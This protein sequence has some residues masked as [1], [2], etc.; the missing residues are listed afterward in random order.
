MTS[1]DGKDLQAE[2]LNLI[3]QGITLTLEE[4]RELGMVGQAGAGR[5]FSD[6]ALS[7]LEVGHEGLTSAF[8]SFCERWEWGVRAL[9]AEGNDFAAGVGLAAGTLYETDQYVEG[10]LKIAT[11][12]LVGNPYA[13]EEE[14]TGKSW[15]QLGND[16]V[17]AYLNPDYSRES[18]DQAWANSKQGWMD[19]GRDVMTSNTMMPPGMRPEDLRHRVGISDEQYEQA[20]DES[21][22]PSPE[23]RAQAAQPPQPEQPQRHWQ[24]RQDGSAG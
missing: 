10:T 2:G 5:G 14:I 22:G 8:T 3:T 4:L 15:S 1:T 19:A 7:G 9:V 13:T 16:T 11:N 24:A 17:D 23:E 20:L 6:I 12:S 18:F 21:F